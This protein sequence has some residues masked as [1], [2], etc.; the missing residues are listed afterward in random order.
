MRLVR[1][2]STQANVYTVGISGADPHFSEYDPNPATPNKKAEYD[3]I[4]LSV[5]LIEGEDK[6]IYKN[7]LF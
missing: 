6:R 2:Q 3:N 7:G 4:N 5:K 1:I